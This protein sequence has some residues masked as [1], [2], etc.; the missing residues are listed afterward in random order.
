MFPQIIRS[1]QLDTP[2]LQQ[3]RKKKTRYNCLFFEKNITR[4]VRRCFH[5]ANIVGVPCKRAKHCSCCATF[6]WSQNN[7][8]VGTCR[9]KSL[10]GT[11]AS[12]FL[13]PCKRTQQVTT[14]LGPTLLGVVGQQC[15]VRL[16]GP[17]G[18]WDRFWTVK[19]LD[20]YYCWRGPK[21]N[22]KNVYV[23]NTLIE[24]F[25]DWV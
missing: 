20:K 10:T 14:L 19:L 25:S 16:H 9:A 4:R 15:C 12:I 23:K 8:N 18:L 1:T 13:V 11:S 17:L 21:Q 7:R 5:E 3:S 24:C 22:C 2:C 6:R